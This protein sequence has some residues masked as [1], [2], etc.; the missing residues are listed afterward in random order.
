MMYW[1]VFALFT[2]AETFT[3]LFISFWYVFIL[4]FI[5]FCVLLQHNLAYK[6]SL[7]F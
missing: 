5:V 6:K 2:C 4:Q 1:I 7:N 3:D